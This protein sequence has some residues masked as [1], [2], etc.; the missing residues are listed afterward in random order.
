MY[1]DWSYSLKTDVLSFLSLVKDTEY[2]VCK[3][4]RMTPFFCWETGSDDELDCPNLF[5]IY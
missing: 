2:S 5:S 1:L 3:S 4:K